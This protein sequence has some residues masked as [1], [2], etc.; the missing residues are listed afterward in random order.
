MLA[1]GA[2]GYIMK[3]AASEQFLG[4]LRHVLEGRIYVSEA[5]GINMIHKLAG[6]GPWGLQ[7]PSTG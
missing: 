1:A 5:V 7:I 2:N 3:Q 6:G 4:S